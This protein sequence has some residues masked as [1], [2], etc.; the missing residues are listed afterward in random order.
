MT[1]L[2]RGGIGCA[3][4]LALVIVISVL[5]AIFGSDK[6]GATKT[7]TPTATVKPTAVGVVKTPVPTRTAKPKPTARPVPTATTATA[8]WASTFNHLKNAEATCWNNLAGTN[9]TPGNGRHIEPILQRAANCFHNVFYSS[10]HLGPSPYDDIG[11]K[12]SDQWLNESV[13]AQALP[14]DYGSS[15]ATADYRAIYTAHFKL[16]TVEQGAESHGY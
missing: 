4:L 8:S 7:A 9:L 1:W 11:G 12:L 15:T 10:V 5:A 13:A 3:G 2:K 6:H 14:Q 16:L